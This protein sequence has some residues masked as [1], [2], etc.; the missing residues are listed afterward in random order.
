MIL[1]SEIENTISVFNSR[2]NKKTNAIY[3]TLLLA[4]LATF[5][6]LPFIY[7]DITSQSRGLI[8]AV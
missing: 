2:Y 5:A 3:I 8:R 6:L 7:V 4:L 1:P